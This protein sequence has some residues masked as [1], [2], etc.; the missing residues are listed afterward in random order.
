M[1]VQF[2]VGQRVVCVDDREHRGARGGGKT[3]SGLKN[4]LVY[5]VREIVLE[6]GYLNHI[7]FRLEELILPLATTGHEYAWESVRF[8]P[9]RTTNIEVFERLL[10]PSPTK[11]LADV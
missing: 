5:T 4:G 9:V 1:G 3:I 6:P 2:H 8:R 10:A 11:E 7:F